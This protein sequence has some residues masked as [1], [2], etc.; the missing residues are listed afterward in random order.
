MRTLFSR[1]ALLCCLLS[2]ACGIPGPGRTGDQTPYPLV[3]IVQIHPDLRAQPLPELAPDAFTLLTAYRILYAGESK[4]LQQIARNLRAM[5]SDTKVL[6]YLTAYNT[7]GLTTGEVEHQHRDAI[8]MVD[9]AVLDGDLGTSGDHVTIRIPDGDEFPFHASTADVSVRSDAFCF[10][11]RI[12]DEY[13]KV[14]EANPADRRLTVERGFGADRRAHRSGTPVLAPVYIGFRGKSPALQARSSQCWPY[15]QGDD[16]IH[17]MLNPAHPGTHRI[18]AAQ[19]SALIELGL[20]GAWL[21][22]FKISFFNMS[23]PLGRRIKYFW[24]DAAGRRY[25]DEE[26]VDALVA[27]VDGIRQGVI[28]TTGV[29]P[30]IAANDGKPEYQRGSK[31]IFRSDENP[32]G[33]DAYDFED[34]FLVPDARRRGQGK[35][36]CEFKLLSHE[37]WLQ[38][39]T[40]LRDA[41]G[42]RLPAIGMIGPAGYLAGYFNP[43]YARYEMLDRFAWCSYLLTVN[44]SRTTFFGKPVVLR[45]QGKGHAFVPLAEYHKLAIGDPVDNKPVAD[46]EIGTSGCYARRFEH[47]IVLVNPTPG[48]VTIPLRGQLGDLAA[49]LHRTS[50]EIRSGDGRILLLEEVK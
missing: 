44:A 25:T 4:L 47:A 31:R 38:N 10:W 27:M 41:A 19:V 40:L 14:L 8:A 5:G 1:R 7:K 37:H 2:A 6:Q 13:M 43:G 33:L 9:V 35:V 46:Y 24:N 49:Q 3:G 22:N 45:Q 20:D 42:D 26:M 12:D 23:D 48:T 18:K 34:C 30:V 29:M 50:F 32:K 11:I 17:Y 28:N 21:D 15:A 36:D 16:G 39:L